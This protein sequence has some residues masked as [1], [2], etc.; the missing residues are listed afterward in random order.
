MFHPGGQN[1]AMRAGRLV[2]LLLLLQQRGR[3]TAADL[4]A[5]LEV[6]VRTIARDIDELSGAG[7]PVYATRGPGGGFQLLEGYRTDLPR[8]A[9][10]TAI[11]RRVGSARRARVRITPEGRRLAAVLQVLQPLRV[12]RSTPTDPSGRLEAT[13]RLRHTETVIVELLSLGPD[14]EVVEP[15]D[16]RTTLATRTNAMARL[17]RDGSDNRASRRAGAWW[18]RAATSSSRRAPRAGR[19]PRPNRRGTPCRDGDLRLRGRGG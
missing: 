10:T 15:A 6:S 12:S 3:V 4:A 8:P 7:V 1:S 19:A 14:V 5:E 18:P 2:A 13:F 17:Y 16:L 11:D 9:S